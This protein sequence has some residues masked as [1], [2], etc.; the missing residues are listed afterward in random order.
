MQK[1]V[2][3]NFELVPININ[4]ELAKL[5]QAILNPELFSKLKQL[6]KDQS[7]YIRVKDFILTCNQSAEVPPGKLGLNKKTREYVYVNLVDPVPV[8]TYQIP[9][10]RESS[11]AYLE[12][13]IELQTALEDKTAKFSID[14]EELDKQLK[15]TM[16]NTF[17]RPKQV[18][19]VTYNKVL[20]V[21]T[22]KKGDIMQIGAKF[23]QN[24]S[25][26]RLTNETEIKYVAKEGQRIDL[27]N[28]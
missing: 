22:V 7:V 26:G 5:N 16:L 20:L 24:E 10:D 11:L 3:N 1:P 17:F 27:K 19:Y 4:N 18:F 15:A 23:Q 13:E 8:N 28:A 12:F 2:S 6:T 9:V 14:D 21:L 25:D